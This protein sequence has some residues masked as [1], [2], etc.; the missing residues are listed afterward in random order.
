MI[1]VYLYIDVIAGM[2]L[3]FRD[4]HYNRFI[5]VIVYNIHTYLSLSDVMA[6]CPTKIIF[7]NMTKNKHEY[8]S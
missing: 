1:I 4:L 5:F 8:N 2:N 6:I 3:R 7:Y